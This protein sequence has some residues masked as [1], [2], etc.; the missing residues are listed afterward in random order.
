MKIQSDKRPKV[1]DPNTGKPYAPQTPD[2]NKPDL[3]KPAPKIN[4]PKI[5]AKPQ[6]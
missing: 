5:P 4:E 3:G 2:T 6:A 1:N